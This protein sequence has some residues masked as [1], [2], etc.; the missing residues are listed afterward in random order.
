MDINDLGVAIVIDDRYSDHRY[1][2]LPWLSAGQSQ[3]FPVPL[4]FAPGHHELTVIV[5][6]GCRGPGR[7]GPIG[8]T[9]PGA[10]PFVSR[11]PET[12]VAAVC[13]VSAVCISCGPQWSQYTGAG[14]K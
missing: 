12:C 10:F 6:P 3:D 1:L 8:R 11:E 5:D 14:G 2:R 13:R 4:E 7:A 9:D